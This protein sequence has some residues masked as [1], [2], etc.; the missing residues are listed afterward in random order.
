MKQD[1]GIAVAIKSI[2]FGDI[3]ATD[4]KLPAFCKR[5]YINTNSNTHEKRGLRVITAG[6]KDKINCEYSEFAD[7]S[8]GEKL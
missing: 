7:L 5:M 4:H 6:N 2:V 1:V 8:A 3:N